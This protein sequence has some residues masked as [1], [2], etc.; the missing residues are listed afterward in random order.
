MLKGVHLET[1]SN[2]DL[3][4]ANNK[5]LIIQAKNIQRIFLQDLVLY[6][7]AHGS[8]PNW[9][10]KGLYGKE[11]IRLVFNTRIEE[12]SIS[13]TYKISEVLVNQTFS[14]R[15]FELI[16]KGK[17]VQFFK[18]LENAPGHY[19]VTNIIAEIRRLF[20]S[21]ASKDFEK[22]LFEAIVVYK[23]WLIPDKKIRAAIIQNFL[24]EKGFKLA[25]GQLIKDDWL[26]I[27]DFYLGR[28]VKGLDIDVNWQTVL[29]K[30]NKYPLRFF[31]VL[32]RIPNPESQ[33]VLI[34]KQLPRNVLIDWFLIITM[35]YNLHFFQFKYLIFLQSK[36]G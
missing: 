2:I 4:R 35:I 3:T 11:T 19:N 33:L 10:E 21:I 28:L 8:F 34:F 14:L 25:S 22:K 30:I 5:L 16:E 36:V 9:V 7:L 32:K 29:E 27:Y 23:V 15:V 18:W 24:L 13:F 26:F 12:G 6:Y 1:Y 20:Q 17:E 31:E